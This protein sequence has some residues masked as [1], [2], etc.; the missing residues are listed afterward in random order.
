MSG[1]TSGKKSTI[2]FLWDPAVSGESNLR[3]RESRFRNYRR[4]S[5]LHDEP[6]FGLLAIMFTVAN[7]CISRS[8]SRTCF[9][10]S[11]RTTEEAGDKFAV[12]VPQTWTLKT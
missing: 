6:V 3:A 9:H 8:T 7:V 10:A 1:G 5:G 12:P 11:C 2:G 4:A